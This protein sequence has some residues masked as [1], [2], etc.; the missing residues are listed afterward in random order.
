MTK[1]RKA[2][3]VITWNWLQ[4]KNEVKP[5]ILV[6]L[7]PHWGGD[8]IISIMQ[9]IYMNAGIHSVEERFR[10]FSNLKHWSCQFSCEGSRII[11]GDDPHLIAGRVDDLEVHYN[12]SSG[13]EEA[14]WTI[15]PGVRMNLTTNKIEEM[16]KAWPMVWK[17]TRRCSNRFHFTFMLGR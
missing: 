7:N 8:R 10:F 17:G 4:D 11:L 6:I 5:N 14:K 16:G 1:K 13:L 9:A 15:P 3:W 12:V 2:A